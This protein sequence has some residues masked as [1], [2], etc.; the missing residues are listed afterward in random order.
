[1]QKGDIVGVVIVGAVLVSI[2]VFLGLAPKAP[3]FV[4]APIEVTGSSVFEVMRIGE[5]SVQVSAAIKQAGFVTLHQAIGDAPGPIIGQ[6]LLLQPGDYTSLVLEATQ[7]LTPDNDYYVLVFAD[8]G[9]GV[10]EAGVDLPVMSD[11][12]VIKQ[13][14]PL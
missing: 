2:A 13:K 12:Q 1:M 5:V 6:S 14:L 9:D 8:D 7:P 10:Y 4:Y 11:G 3:V